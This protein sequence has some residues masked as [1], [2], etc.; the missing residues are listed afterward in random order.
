M[1]EK[2]FIP[3]CQ[4][5]K[6]SRFLR[7][8]Q[9]EKEEKTARDAEET[10]SAQSLRREGK[11]R[12]QLA[13]LL[14]KDVDCDPV[15][16]SNSFLPRRAEPDSLY[17]S[18]KL[19]LACNPDNTLRDPVFS[20]HPYKGQPITKSTITL[21]EITLLQQ[22]YHRVLASWMAILERSYYW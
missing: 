9:A 5:N 2:S 18:S 6:I 10:N 17:I 8:I 13:A 19:L 11:M 7:F 3:F 20:A 15:C 12:F 4:T 21:Y 1:F 14:L 22:Q 16:V